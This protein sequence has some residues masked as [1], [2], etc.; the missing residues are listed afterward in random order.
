MKRWSFLSL[1]CLLGNPSVQAADEFYI[2][3]GTLFNPPQIDAINFINNGTFNIST[4]QVGPIFPSQP[5]LPFETSNTT[6]F[7]NNGTM[8]GTPGWRFDN[9]AASDGQRRWATSFVNRLGGVVQAVDP[10][11]LIFIVQSKASRSRP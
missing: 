8:I 11:A 3:N 10:L 1:V 4:V 6:N 5:S 2:N 9:G 7:V